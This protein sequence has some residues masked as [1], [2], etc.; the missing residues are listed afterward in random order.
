MQVP[1]TLKAINLPFAHFFSQHEKIVI[2]MKSGDKSRIM[3]KSEVNPGNIDSTQT[4]VVVA[5]SNN[6]IKVIYIQWT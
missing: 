1:L 6:H 2:M 5:L 4:E 3:L